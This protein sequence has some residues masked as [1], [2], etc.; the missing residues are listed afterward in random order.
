MTDTRGMGADQVLFQVTPPEAAGG[1]VVGEG[2]QAGTAPDSLRLLSHVMMP[3]LRLLTCEMEPQHL[4]HRVPAQKKI[5]EM[6]Y[7]I[8]N[9][10]V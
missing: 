2:A 1:R 8:I 6:K 10:W 9:I 3:S 4:H 5:M 7:T